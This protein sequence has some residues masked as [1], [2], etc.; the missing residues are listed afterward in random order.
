MLDH[1]GVKREAA[2]NKGKEQS[3]RAESSK[4]KVQAKAGFNLDQRSSRCN[5]FWENLSSHY[6]PHVIVLITPVHPLQA[7]LIFEDCTFV[8]FINLDLRYSNY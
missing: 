5:F 3:K 8:F 6:A 1:C 7:Y 2:I 4:S